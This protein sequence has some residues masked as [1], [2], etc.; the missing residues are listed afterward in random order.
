MPDRIAHRLNVRIDECTEIE[1][2]YSQRMLIRGLEGRDAYRLE[3]INAFLKIS[4]FQSFGNLQQDQNMLNRLSDKIVS[5]SLRRRNP[6]VYT[7]YS[8]G[9]KTNIYYGM[10]GQLSESIENEIQAEL[11]DVRIERAWI[12]REKIYAV[13]NYGGFVYGVGQN[14]EDIIDDLL[15]G[16]P[17]APFMISILLWP[18]SEESICDELGETYNLIDICSE[19][20]RGRNP[21]NYHQNQRG[22][23]ELQRV[24]NLLGNLNKIRNR[25]EDGKAS[26]LWRSVIYVSAEQENVYQNIISRVELEVT[27]GNGRETDFGRAHHVDAPFRFIEN[28]PGL[29]W[30][31]PRGYLGR[32][33]YGGLFSDT[34]INIVNNSTAR[35]LFQLPHDSH[36]GYRVVLHD[37]ERKKLHPF[38][39]YE[40][41]NKQEGNICLGYS[42][43]NEFFVQKN[44]LYSHAFVTGRTRS[45]KSTTMRKLLYELHKEGIPFLVIEPAK[46]EYC[47]LL[48]YEEFK[49]VR[50]Y[51]CGK[52]ALDF[53]M[54]PFQPEEGTLFSKHMEGLSQVFLTL[55]SKDDGAI[56]VLIPQLIQF[57]Y[58][59]CDIS[60]NSRYYRDDELELPTISDMIDY[61]EEFVKSI[62]YEPDTERQAIAVIT[63]RE[64]LLQNYARE[65]FD[66]KEGLDVA[67]L[68]SSSA[69]VEFE[70]LGD[71]IK[72]FAAS[73]LALRVDEYSRQQ[74]MER[75][76]KRLLVL[77]EAHHLVPNEQQGGI[78]SVQVACSKYFANMLAEIA[79][80]G[81]GLIVVDQRPSSVSSAVIANT[82]IKIIHSLE[83]KEDKDAV[84]SALN[85][86]SS[87][88]LNELNQ[89][90]AVVSLP[91][92]SGAFK[93]KVEMI[94]EK[95]QADMSF[96]TNLFG[97]PSFVDMTRVIDAANI[98]KEIQQIER[99]LTPAAVRAGVSRV[100]QYTPKTLT[101]EERFFVALA[102]AEYSSAD[103][104]QKRQVL[105]EYS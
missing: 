97:K 1:E 87:S 39:T 77:E 90:E 96:L 31:I 59:K 7:F 104:L 8:D 99:K 32:S 55:F 20:Q 82:G 84:C 105:Y 76:T 3:G 33:N 27:R 78:T 79:A 21:G 56:S 60:L 30:N 48:R 34:A 86:G 44:E 89:G 70:D 46:K 37:E 18:V 5:A 17:H 81:T 98:D 28:L 93:V 63:L 50:V 54:N 62:H 11:E 67:E 45:G 75:E 102:L 71:D 66:T 69:V 73:L 52:D 41:R 83:Q 12:R 91:G 9:E 24:E 25:L 61:T 15:R 57:C 43:G 72:S 95:R 42:N 35:A 38:D 80:Y 10:E 16:C 85:I 14:V 100:E 22:Q 4:G 74:P 6:I 88:V 101:Q 64:R 2:F 23:I 58:E 26:G 29:M 49:K 92:D 40:K 36:D 47:E 103:Y 65:V 53:R 94:S 19:I 13:Q 68:F 51:S